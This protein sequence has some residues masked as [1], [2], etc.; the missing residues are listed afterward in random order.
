[1]LDKNPWMRP[2]SIDEVFALPFNETDVIGCN[3]NLALQELGADCLSRLCGNPVDLVTGQLKDA[4][5][6]LRPYLKVAD[7]WN[8]DAACTLQGMLKDVEILKDCPD[9]AQV[10]ADVLFQLGRMEAAST[11]M[12]A[13]ALADLREQRIQNST[14]S[15]SATVE[16]LRSD[17][18]IHGGWHYGLCNS[19]KWPESSVQ[20]K[21]GT[22]Y[23]VFSQ[24]MCERCQKYCLDYSSIFADLHYIMHEAAVEEKFWNGIRDQG[25]TG[26]RLAHFM[27]LPQ[28]V[29]ARLTE[30]ELVALRFYTS[31]SFNSLVAPLRDRS[32]LSSHPL[33]GMV[34]NIQRG[35][36]KLRA[37]GSD[38][39]S[40]KQTV[41]FWRGM[42]DRKLSHEFAVHGGTDVSPMST[43]TDIG[44]A[45]KYCVNRAMETRSLLVLRI[46]TRNN[47]ERGADV[48]WLSMFPG[49]SETLF[50]PLTFLQ[51]THTP[52]QE[53]VNN[54]VTVTVVEVSTTLA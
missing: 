17:V 40:S 22:F 4:A 3:L 44:I 48:Q 1:L 19:I 53:V 47:L 33:P 5:F 27:A 52:P 30:A 15:A 45:V 11:R 26:R 31:H 51:R 9:C 7:H 46:V 29:E 39:A 6:G 37:L 8:E 2:R 20:V 21:C 13:R 54:G 10:Q 35:L 18:S 36:K 12:L 43:T 42:R 41:V 34:I 49:E 14:L 16:A 50:P 32:Y 25:R 23:K 24:P 38:D 28:A